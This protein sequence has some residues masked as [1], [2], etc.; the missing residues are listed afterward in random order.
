M[1]SYSHKIL[2]FKQR[3][4]IIFLINVV[5]SINLCAK[6]TLP[7]L[8]SDNMILQR[9]EP[10]AVWG[11]AL[12]GERISISFDSK[13]YISK[14]SDKDG[15]W[16]VKLK[17]HQAGGPFS[18]EIKGE[19][20]NISLSNILIGEVWL[21]S[22]QSNMA[23]DFNNARA[24]SLYRDDILKSSND[25][26]RQI[27]IE[28]NIS[29]YP[30]KNVN[31]S[32]WIT[33][34]PKNLNTFSAIGYFFALQLY[35]KYH[36][37]IGLINSS[38][39]GT[40]A[41]AWISEKGLKKFPEF[42]QDIN[43]LH[44]S[45]ALELKVEQNKLEMN[46]WDSRLNYIDPGIGEN[47]EP[48]WAKE[49][50]DSVKWTVL[51]HSGLLNMNGFAKT[52][53]SFWYL[54]QIEIPGNFSGNNVTV[55]L[56]RIDDADV[57]YFNGHLIGS[58]NNRDLKRIYT[59]PAEV[60]K[61]GK[62][63]L[64]VRVINYSGDGGMLDKDSVKMTFNTD[65]DLSERWIVRE[66]AIMDDKPAKYETKNL[67]TSLF[68]KMI[69][70]LL[71]YRIRGILWYQGEYNTQKAFYYRKL[72]PALIHDW[73]KHW[74]YELPFIYVQLPNFQKKEEFPVESEWAELREAQ[75]MALSLPKTAMAVTI[76]LGESN[77]IHPVNKKDVAY[78]LALAAEKMVYREKK[79]TA[80]GPT[81]KSMKI[82][83]GK[84]L[85]SFEKGAALKNTSDKLKYFSIAGADRRFVWAEAKFVGHHHLEVSSI[86][87]PFPVAVRYA[88]SG[89][90]EKINLYNIYGLP[91]SP[92]RTDNWPGI[93]FGK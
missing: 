6:I 58:S 56:G 51:A 30:N 4:I 64:L 71:P 5:F 87:V 34:E 8:V 27:L 9:D 41:Q 69:S 77:D 45:I 23:F 60:I 61:K 92:F 33:A 89:N 48:I 91:A 66:G 68:N 74:G 49:S 57:T 78:R 90:P 83:K 17:P 29:S 25:N 43:L 22:G 37:P 80:S 13:I 18:M 7:T 75:S 73:R 59:V 67:S 31:S 32:G 12:P 36:V 46:Q 47:G 11:W 82:L 50:F 21:C 28:R 20:E 81:Y 16:M 85:I 39:G 70:P 38:F 52:Q 62:N 63:L 1:L 84:I 3:L 76:D 40:M 42:D 14:P 15:K 2:K 24:K 79:I 65:I 53:G 88:W 93:T 54:K 86:D 19:H 44:D 26:I 72:F 35:Q 55:S 10:I